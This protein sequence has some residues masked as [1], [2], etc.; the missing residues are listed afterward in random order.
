[1]P[2]P[3]VLR[4]SKNLRLG[5]IPL[6]L[7]AVILLWRF[8]AP[9]TAR[10]RTLDQGPVYL[11][12]RGTGTLESVQEVP[13][14]FKVGGRIQ[15]LPLDEGSKIRV[16]Q[17]L[18]RLDPSDLREMLTV[19]E[20]GRGAAEAFRGKTQAD[21][22][23]AIAT[24]QRARAD[25]ERIQRL[26]EQ[27][28]ISKSELELFQERAKLA[29]AAVKATEAARLQASRGE[30]AARGTEAIQRINYK[31]VQLLSPVDGI[32]TRRLR[33]PGNVIA[34]GTPVLT[35]ASTRKLWVR[36]WVDEAALGHLRIGQPARVELR[37]AAGRWIPGRVDRIGR[38]SDR[39]THELLVDVELLE[40][41]P[42]F[43]L[44]QRADVS[45]QTSGVAATLRL[46]AGWAESDGSV[47]VQ[48]HGR[49]TRVKPV[50]GFQGS[51]FVEVKEGLELGDVVLRPVKDGN[52]LGAGRRVR[53]EAA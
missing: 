10:T 52:P 5:L 16:G 29:E 27:G 7:F 6:S 13:L 34:G 30:S 8:T 47:F 40:L 49:V 19:A 15:E 32:L 14:A 46:P 33:E 3:A 4:S 26:F 1:M 31:E 18:G 28:I 35:V 48:R 20:A 42:S 12:V 45:I 11:E 9:V 41:P 39:Q 43:A 23:Q 36:T 51:D 37:S 24:R 44:G 22:E 38:Q 17:V 53:G 21:L 25:V 50:L 2:I